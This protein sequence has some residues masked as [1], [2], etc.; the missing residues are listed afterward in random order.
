MG[1]RALSR[2]AFGKSIAEH[3]AFASEFAQCIVKLNAARLTVLDAADFLDKHGN[4]KVSSCIIQMFFI[5]FAK[6]WICAGIKNLSIEDISRMMEFKLY[7]LLLLVL[8]GTTAVDPFGSLSFYFFAFP[9]HIYSLLIVH[10][11]TQEYLSTAH[12]HYEL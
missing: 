5:A 2:R 9:W 8:C 10:K 3:G 1:E 11:E 4:K 6:I 7:D 12:T